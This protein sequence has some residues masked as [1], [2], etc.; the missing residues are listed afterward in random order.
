[1][2]EADATVIATE[3][4]YAWVV[5]RRESACCHCATAGSCGVSALGKAL[6]TRPDRMRLPDPLSLQTGERVVI[7]IAEERLLSAAFR[8]YM[9]P[10]LCMLGA[11]LTV[12]Q[13]GFSQWVIGFCSLAALAASL[14]WPRRR[15][16]AAEDSSR[17]VLLRRARDGEANSG[18][19]RR[20]SR[21]GRRGA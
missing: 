8:A 20:G 5:T 17:P 12:A 15:G 7:G 21:A 1:M 2:I 13:Q 4:G 3:A 19:R 11:A 9:V 6:G 16:K 10:L 18:W 14:A